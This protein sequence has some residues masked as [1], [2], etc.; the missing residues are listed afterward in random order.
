ML[1]DGGLGESRWDIKLN[2]KTNQ[3]FP[4]IDRNQQQLWLL[5]T[6]EARISY[7]IFST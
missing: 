5:L 6:L 4:V 3:K 7:F 2:E 1:Y